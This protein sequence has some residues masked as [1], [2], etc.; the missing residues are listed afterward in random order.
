MFRK[1]MIVAA[2]VA[3]T[4]LIL[5]GAAASADASVG[6]IQYTPTGADSISG[7]Y[8]HALNDSVDFTHITSY[9]GSDGSHTI[10]QLPVTSISGGKLTGVIGGAAGIG[11][12]NQGTG[13]AAQVGLVYAGSGTVDVVY[14]TGNFSAGNNGDLCQ[15]GIVNPSGLNGTPTTVKPNPTAETTSFSYTPSSDVLVVTPGDVV[16]PTG[17]PVNFTL[18]GT[19][20]GAALTAAQNALTA[21]GLTPAAGGV[22]TLYVVHTTATTF[23]VSSNKGAVPLT[24]PAASAGVMAG[25]ASVTWSKPGFTI[26]PGGNLDDSFGVLATGIPDNNTVSLDVLYDA[27]HSYTFKGKVH[28]AGTITFSATNLGAPGVT[29]QAGVSAPGRSFNEADTGVIAD[30]NSITA[31]TGTAPLPDG[32]ANLLERF[33]HVTLAGNPVGGGAAVE[34]SLQDNANWTAFPVASANGGVLYLAPS[35]FLNDHFSELVGAPVANAG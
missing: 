28:A 1:L 4:A 29:Y 15:G 26:V 14:G 19:L 24:V 5:G 11:L 25:T 20:T 33:A 2:P 13:A 18:P 8:A 21:L 6:P 32:N 35:V 10:E 23:E 9:A 27:A 3:V 7:Y 12:C 30:T 22:Y 16:P 17:T 34:G 31:L